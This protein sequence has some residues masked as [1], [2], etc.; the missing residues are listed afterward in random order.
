MLFLSLNV[1]LKTTAKQHSAV[2]C[3]IFSP[4]LKVGSSHAFK[5]SWTPS[6][7]VAWTKEQKQLRGPTAHT[8]I[9]DCDTTGVHFKASTGGNVLALCA[10]PLGR[11]GMSL[12]ALSHVTR[13]VLRLRYG[14]DFV[15]SLRHERE[16]NF[17]YEQKY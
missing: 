11:H 3:S 17:C 7:G 13:G 12:V 5:Q 4:L 14:L 16:I 15:M 9:L 1:P 8:Q 6:L 2:V 10:A